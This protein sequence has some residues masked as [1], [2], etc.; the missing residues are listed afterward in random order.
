MIKN[1]IIDLNDKE[2]IIDG[3]LYQH[4]KHE[5]KMNLTDIERCID[6]GGIKVYEK[7]ENNDLIELTKSNLDVVH[8]VKLTRTVD[9]ISVKNTVEREHLEETKQ[10]ELKEEETKQE[11]VEQKPEAETANCKN[12]NS[13]RK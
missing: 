4:G 12:K 10:E 13:K 6:K 3:V 8:K 11:E 7:L 2:I 9:H 5:L 1:C